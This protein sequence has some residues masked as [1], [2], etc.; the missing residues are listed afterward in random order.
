MWSCLSG[1]A[2]LCASSRGPFASRAVLAP[3]GA[4][5]TAP[6]NTFLSS[7]A[8][9]NADMCV[10]C[11]EAPQKEVVR[12]LNKSHPH[13]ACKECFEGELMCNLNF[14]SAEDLHKH[15]HAGY[16]AKACVPCESCQSPIVA[17]NEVNRAL[18]QGILSVAQRKRIQE[19]LRECRRRDGHYRGEYLGGR[20]HGKNGMLRS[21]DGHEYTGDFADG[22]CNGKGTLTYGHDL[23]YTGQWRGGKWH[24]Y[25]TER[26]KEGVLYEGQ[27]RDGQ[28]HG[29][30]SLVFHDGSGKGDDYEGE[31]QRGKEHGQ[32]TRIF[33]RDGSTYKGEFREGLQHGWGR[34]T[35]R[36]GCSY[37]G[38][39]EYDQRHGHGEL[40]GRRCYY[41]RGQP[42]TREYFERKFLDVEQEQS[43]AEEN[44]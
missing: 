14:S 1:C 11:G 9:D 34:E 23:V 42:V 15:L 31:W 28:R 5:I 35:P 12:C 44:Q 43:Q 36:F 21:A 7:T 40:G 4:H 39:F 32:G 30:G 2:S 25:G 8:A 16:E 19:H 22:A 27:W 38:Q 24:G 10:I 18:R 37:E 41:E 13:V 29:H 33:A 17:E 3:G 6:S 20:R 26:V